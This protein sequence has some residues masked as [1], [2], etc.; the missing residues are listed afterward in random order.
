PLP[1]AGEE[2]P[3]PLIDALVRDRIRRETLGAAGLPED[4][5]LARYAAAHDGGRTP[6]EAWVLTYAMDM[7][8]RCYVG[9]EDPLQT[10]A[11][12][13]AADRLRLQA[14]LFYLATL[15]AT[16][17]LSFFGALVVGRRRDEPTR[18]A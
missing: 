17:V 12:D 15:G 9:Y 8:R 18:P 1:A 2:E 5:P 10:D 14:R 16:I 11:A 13:Q 3:Y 4:G 6:E 7:Q